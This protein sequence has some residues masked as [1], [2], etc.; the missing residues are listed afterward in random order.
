MKQAVCLV[1]NVEKRTVLVV[2]M[3][4]YAFYQKTRAVHRGIVRKI[5]KM[6]VNG[7][8]PYF[9]RFIEEM[10]HKVQLAMQFQSTCHFI[11]ETVF[12]RLLFSM[13]ST[14]MDFRMPCTALI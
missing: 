1:L 14:T 11:S 5:L 12:A 6:F 9:S 8:Q 2:V 10:D 13:S 3:I 7:I 4:S